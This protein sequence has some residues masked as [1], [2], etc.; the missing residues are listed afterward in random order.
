MVRLAD[1]SIDVRPADALAVY[2]KAIAPLYQ[3]TGD[4]VYR[5]MAT[6]LVSA[7]SCH[8]ALGTPDEFE[9][10]LDVIRTDLK[11]KRNLMRILDEN[12]L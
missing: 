11:R 12:G 5:R 9:R 3:L 6:L 1:A 2:L 10:Y 7:R 8:Q 4:D